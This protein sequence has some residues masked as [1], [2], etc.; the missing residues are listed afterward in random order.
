MRAIL[1]ILGLVFQMAAAAQSFDQSHAA[2]S[3]V[4]SDYVAVYDDGLK[5]AVSYRELSENRL[6]LDNYLASLSAVEPR[7]YESWTHE[8]KL[9]FLINAYNGFTLQLIIDNIDKFESGEAD[10]IR[11]L[12]GL[13]ASPWEKSFFTLLGEKRTLDWVEHEKIRGDFD[14]P[15]IHASLVCA[16]VNCPKLRAEAF[17]GESLETQLE[18]QMVTFLN[19]R[20][21]NGI[22]DKGIYLS[23]IFDWYRED[24]DGLKDYLRSYRGALSY[25]S[26]SSD[27]M[28]F[29]SLDIRFVDYNWKLNNLE[30]R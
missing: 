12:G 11:D 10:S 28:N 24:F 15:R 7:Q 3:D 13:F 9:A 6:P 20:D 4:L 19:D 14:E 26:S 1:F 18:D 30:N 8:Q 25:G 17:T 21:K 22:D 23:K 2:F 29:Q 5:S 16:A 27:N